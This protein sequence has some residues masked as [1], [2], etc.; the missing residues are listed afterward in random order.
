MNR[1]FLPELIQSGPLQAVLP[2][3]TE[4]I[5]REA[6]LRAGLL[7]IQRP[8]TRLLTICGPGGV[9]KSRLAHALARQ[10]SSGL[11]DG[12]LGVALA[13]VRT[14]EQFYQAL[15]TA[16]SEFAEQPASTATARA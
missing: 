16:S 7:L 13:G 6:E 11:R 14:S 2:C 4:L 8:E 3:S 1:P 9:G 10:A 5:G 15:C 12:V